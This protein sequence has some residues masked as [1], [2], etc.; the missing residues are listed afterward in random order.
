MHQRGIMQAGEDYIAS[1]NPTA[2]PDPDVS[3]TKSRS[4]RSRVGRQ[5]SWGPAIPSLEVIPREF[6]AYLVGPPAILEKFPARP[7]Y[8][9]QSIRR[10]FPIAVCV[11]R[12]CCDSAPNP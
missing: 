4:G 3:E 10:V 5:N 12:K 8:R 1:E 9:S 11:L 2:T 7:E 6:T